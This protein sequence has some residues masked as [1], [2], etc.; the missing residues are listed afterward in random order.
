MVCPL[1]PSVFPS[2]FKK[3]GDNILVSIPDVEICETFGKTWEEAYEMG[4]DAL[5]ACLSEAETIIHPRTTKERLQK[6]NPR[7]E[8]V[9]IPVDES[10]RKKYMKTKRFNVI[11]PE[12]LLTR[13]DKYRVNAGLK[14]SQLLATAA[15][16][17][18][19][20]QTQV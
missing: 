16:K 13:V 10:I 20:E 15:E 18:L 11:F 19:Q 14:L 4:V 5:A 17:Y 2:V 8:I 6:D 9:P 12:E 3:E 7:A 1:F